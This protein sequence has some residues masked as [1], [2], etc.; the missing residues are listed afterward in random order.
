M[1]YPK[2]KFSTN[3]NLDKHIAIEFLSHNFRGGIDFSQCIF[4]SQP[5]IKN[6]ISCYIDNFYKYHQKS[7]KK[8]SYKFQKVWLEMASDFFNAA[9][10]VFSRHKWPKGKYIGYISI[11]NCGPRFLDD[12][13]FQIFYRHDRNYAVFCV[14]HEMLHFIFYDYIEKKRKDV[15]NKLTEDQLWRISEIVNEVLLRPEYLGKSLNISKRYKGYPD[16]IPIANKIV[17]MFKKDDGIGKL[18]NLAIK[19]DNN[20]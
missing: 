3:K 18:I 4:G 11:F 14:A 9:D 15:K 5:G 7:F 10:T 8:I 6:S 19:F 1:Y 20:A 2:V 12:K 13:T 16:F 17:K